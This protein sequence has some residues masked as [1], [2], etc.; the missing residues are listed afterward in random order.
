MRLE[1]PLAL[2]NLNLMILKRFLLG[3]LRV[4]ARRNCCAP[5]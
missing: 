3:L 4:Y 2:E 1:E 5:P